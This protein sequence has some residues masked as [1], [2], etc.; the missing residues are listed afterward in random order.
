MD[1]INELFENE[2]SGVIHA[3]PS[4]YTKDD[5]TELLS[6]LRTVVLTEAAD[7]L[8]KAN[9]VS[10]TEELFQEFASDVQNNLERSLCT[11]SIEVYD[12]GSAEFSIDYNNRIQIENIDV[13]T[14]NI[15]D[16]LHDILL[17]QFQNHFGKF[18][19]NNPE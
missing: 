11:G 19:I 13:L 8:S 14:D 4:I 5:V 12:T 17:D 15:T 10:I 16:E 7:A 2:L 1:K 9:S 3:Y 18:L 6:K